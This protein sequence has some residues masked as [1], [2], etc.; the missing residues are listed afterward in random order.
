[1]SRCERTPP[2]ATPVGEM[3]RTQSS[4][5]VS[6]TQKP[7]DC[8]TSK[9]TS[10]NKNK[11]QR[12]NPSPEAKT[13]CEKASQSFE[14]RIMDM[15]MSWKKEQDSLLK[16]LTSDM[17]EIKQQIK[18]MQKSYT[19]TEKWRDYMDVEYESMKLTIATLD[20]ERLEQRDYIAEL[21]KKV[22]DLQTSARSSSIEIRN[23]A[24]SESESTA[25][26]T[27]IVIKTCSAI[28]ED[29]PL[30]KEN[31]KIKK[32]KEIRNWRD[33][34]RGR[35]GYARARMEISTGDVLRVESNAMN[36]ERLR[37]WEDWMQKKRLS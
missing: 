25:D 19:E 33:I 14:E 8:G 26:L 9:I 18:D 30:H 22:E 31:G 34:R 29:L 13:V 23:V 28:Q 7:T 5:D 2:A 20:K 6:A 36:M 35:E 11:R 24:S 3:L 15:L 21:E 16:R 17:T 32:D 37:R 12:P 4:P 10:R 1:M 27:N